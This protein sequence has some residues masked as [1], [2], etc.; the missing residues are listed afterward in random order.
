MVSQLDHLVIAARTLD[1]G[2][3]WCEATLGVVPSA[4][5]RHDF[6]GTHNRVFSIATAA[7]PLAYLEIIA[8]DPAAPAPARPRWFALDT[9]EGAPRLHHWVARC[10]D[11]EAA[12]AA[13]IAAGQPDPGRVTDAARGALRWRITVPDDGAR[14]APTLIQWTSPH[15]VESM[16]ASG[17]ELLGFATEPRLSAR[18]QTPRGAVTLAAS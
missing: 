6:M 3:S 12:R 14:V 5:G 2:L 1:E 16:P 13:T 8:I 15:P 7:W 17:V 18:L 10:D 11:V 9:F 4:G